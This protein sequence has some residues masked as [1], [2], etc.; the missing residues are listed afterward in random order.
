MENAAILFAIF[1]LLVIL[2]GIYVFTG[3]SDIFPR[4]YSVP[5][6]KAY[7]KFL[8]KKIIIVGSIILLLSLIFGLE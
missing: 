5:N 6:D 2:V 8:G 4:R 7:L 3:H 1:G